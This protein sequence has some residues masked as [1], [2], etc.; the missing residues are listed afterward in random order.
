MFVSV[1][2]KRWVRSAPK[3]KSAIPT[4]LEL[5]GSKTTKYL[6]RQLYIDDGL[7]RIGPQAVPA[8]LELCKDR[9][10]SIRLHATEAIGFLGP[11]A[12]SAAPALT[13]LLK[14]ESE[15]VR[16]SAAEALKEITA[17]TK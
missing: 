3:R 8:L 6:D 9:D 4:L 16:A 2:L 14:D 1:P 11:A 10:E 17:E 7:R 15:E 5:A 13:T 12:K